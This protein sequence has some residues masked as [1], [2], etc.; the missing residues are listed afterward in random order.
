[1][2]RNE[3]FTGECTDLSDQGYGVLRHKGEVVFVPGLLPQEKARIRVILAKKNFAIGRA[4]ER[5]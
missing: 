4:M 3:E 2:K 1:M 5:L